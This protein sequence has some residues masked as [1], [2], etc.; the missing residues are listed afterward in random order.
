M[1]DC[2][3]WVIGVCTRTNQKLHACRMA[4]MTKMIA[5]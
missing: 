3:I 4:D 1:F 5:K 2:Q